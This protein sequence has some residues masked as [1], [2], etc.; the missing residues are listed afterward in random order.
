MDMLTQWVQSLSPY[1]YISDPYVVYVKN[2]VTSFVNYTSIKLGGAVFR[3]KQRIW[4][5]DHMWPTQ[6]KIVT[7]WP[8]TEKIFTDSCIN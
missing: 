1:F 5:R 2:L 6:P 4:E 7:A 8:F 3:R